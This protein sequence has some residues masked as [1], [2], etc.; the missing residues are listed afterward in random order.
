M[1]E[2]R[3]PAG[4]KR[5]VAERAQHCCEY[6]RSQA[7]VATTGFSIEHINP[8]VRGGDDDLD[9]LALA[10]Q[11]CN[12]HKFDKI[13]A[14]DPISGTWVPL[15]NPR[16]DAWRAHFAWSDDY[17]LMI[18]LTPMG[19]ATIDALRLNRSG[20]VSLRRVLYALGEHPLPDVEG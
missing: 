7:R 11:G 9:N 13:E 4:L 8:K 1:P 18:G 20:V 17:T 2:G 14:R 16:R 10:C 5:R 3:V 6:C 12:N 15:Y 19:R